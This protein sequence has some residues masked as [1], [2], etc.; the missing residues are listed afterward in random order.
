MR[1][2]YGSGLSVEI[3]E[4]LTHRNEDGTRM[5][6]RS[7]EHQKLTAARPEDHEEP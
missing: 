1:V 2:M 4:C 3:E 7:I 5:V 6:V